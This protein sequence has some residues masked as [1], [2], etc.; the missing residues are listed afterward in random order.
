M[1]PKQHMIIGT[2]CPEGGVLTLRLATSDWVAS[3]PEAPAPPPH[4]AQ[5]A[6]AGASTSPPDPHQLHLAIQR[7]QVPASASKKTRSVRQLQ[8]HLAYLQRQQDLPTGLCGGWNSTAQERL[9]AWLLAEVK[10]ARPTPLAIE[11]GEVEGDEPEGSEG[12][13]MEEII[14]Q[15]IDTMPGDSDITGKDIEAVD[16]DSDDNESNMVE[17]PRKKTKSQDASSSSSSSS[18]ASSDSSAAGRR[19]IHL[20]KAVGHLDS[21]LEINADCPDCLNII[22]LAK[23]EVNKCF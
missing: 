19:R 23:Q 1:A 7:G 9:D 4:A 10:G 11:D 18:S 15:D 3:S 14:G 21:L 2:A 12:I 16:I 22:E 13:A 6:K 8:S 20:N 17:P 5:A